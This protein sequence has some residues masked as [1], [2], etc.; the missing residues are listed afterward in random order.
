MDKEEKK[1]WKKAT[2]EVQK[3]LIDEIKN[4]PIK[5][6]NEPEIALYVV[7]IKLERARAKL[8]ESLQEAV[9]IVESMHHGKN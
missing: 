5:Y 7:A 6:S 8:E 3:M 4:A 9:V 2:E 1:E